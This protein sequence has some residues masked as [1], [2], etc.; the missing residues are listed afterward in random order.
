MAGEYSDW[1]PIGHMEAMA[2]FVSWVNFNRKTR[3][4]LVTN[5]C[6]HRLADPKT[7][8]ERYG[9]YWFHYC[10]VNRQKAALVFPLC[11]L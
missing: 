9:K 2:Q 5:R 10:G 1:P 8:Y 7:P 11:L 3:G 4:Y 6:C